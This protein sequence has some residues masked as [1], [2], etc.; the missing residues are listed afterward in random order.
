MIETHPVLNF[1][2]NHSVPWQLKELFFLFFFLNSFPLTGE[3]NNY[4]Y[5]RYK[6]IETEE[7]SCFNVRGFKKLVTEINHYNGKKIA[8]ETLLLHF[9]N[10]REQFHFNMSFSDSRLRSR[11]FICLHKKLLA[12]TILSVWRELFWFG[13]FGFGFFSTQ[14]ALGF[15][16]KENRTLATVCHVRKLGE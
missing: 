7:I 4:Y 10:V 15:Q 14:W 8:A 9:G 16:K 13:W 6:I 1:W 2:Q 3:S 5:K 12:V 11:K